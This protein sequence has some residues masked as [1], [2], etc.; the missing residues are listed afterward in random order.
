MKLG[1][2]TLVVLSSL[3]FGFERAAFAQTFTCIYSGN[4]TFAC[5]GNQSSTCDPLNPVQCPSGYVCKDLFDPPG[6]PYPQA[7]DEFWCFSSDPCAGTPAKCGQYTAIDTTGALFFLGYNCPNSQ[8]TSPN[9]CPG[10]QV[11]V[12][13]TD[14]G[15][16]CQPATC[17]SLGAVC[18][19]PPD[20]CGGHVNCTGGPGCSAGQVCTS[21]GQCC[22]PSACPA[23]SCGQHNDGCGS[24]LQCNCGAGQVCN[25][26][27]CCTQ[28][29]CPA[30]SCGVIPDGC[31]GVTNCGTPPVGTACVNNQVVACTHTNCTALHAN[32]GTYNDG[33]CNGEIVNCGFCAA[34]QYC[35]E[36][37][38]QRVCLAGALPVPALPAGGIAILGVA[39]AGVAGALIRR[40]K[41]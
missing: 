2:T 10:T 1:F 27:T 36:Q 5:S 30:N 21:A 34:N 29:S 40:S 6:T 39:L 11:C 17:A 12:G 31:G 19:F 23:N 22:T 13:G 20:G 35:G 28:A 38:G 9:L 32:C 7:G 24:I 25:G 3:L 41:R 37:S 8:A 4:S 15:L 16:C 33:N 18:G 26:T 14:R